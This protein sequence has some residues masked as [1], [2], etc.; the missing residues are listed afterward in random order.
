MHPKVWVVAELV[1]AG[2]VVSPARREGTGIQ[3]TG[4][5]GIHRAFTDAHSIQTR[6][7]F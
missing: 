5:R 6:Q 3:A 1:A 7:L 4:H 2:A